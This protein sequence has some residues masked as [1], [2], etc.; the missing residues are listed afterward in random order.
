VTNERL[1]AVIA[2][3]LP[4]VV[5]VGPDFAGAAGVA[6][7]E[8]GEPLTTEHRFRIGSVTKIFVG[9]LVLELVAEGAFNLDDD[10]GPLVEGVT[11]RQLLNHTSGLPDFQDDMAALFERYQEDLNYRWPLGRRDEL[12]L[13]LK[14]PRLFAPGEGWAYHG[15]NY[16]ALGLLIEDATGSK[17]G[18]ELRSRIFEPLGLAGTD[19]VDGPLSGDRCARGYLPPD[20]PVLPGPG[21]GMVDV[22]QL[23]LPFYWA[24]GGIVSTAG[25]VATMLAV[26]LGGELLPDELRVE[27]LQAVESDWA[28][29]D[30]YGLGIGEMSTVMR[31]ERSQ[32]GPAWGHIGFSAGYTAI[33]VASEDGSRQVVVM[34]NGQATSEDVWDASWDAIGQLLWDL[35]CT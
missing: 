23:D 21:P 19:L 3:G 34:A 24:G 7:I 12:A 31:R 4:G 15:S 6:N 8:T 20:N 27:M 10:A 32:C 35:Y 13:V 1:H 17:L 14:R 22:T 25:D 18:D 11:I 16:L 5:A 2:A 33:A 26:L 30:R 28:E 29:T 9:A